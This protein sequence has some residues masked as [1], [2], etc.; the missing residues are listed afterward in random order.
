MGTVISILSSIRGGNFMASL[1]LLKVRFSDTYPTDFWEIS[2]PSGWC[3]MAVQSPGV[4]TVDLSLACQSSVG[5]GSLEGYLFP[6]LPLWLV[7]DSLDSLL[8]CQHR[9]HFLQFFLV[10]GIMMN[11]FIVTRYVETLSSECQALTKSM[12]KSFFQ[13]II[14]TLIFKKPFSVWSCFLSS[15]LNCYHMICKNVQKHESICKMSSAKEPRKYLRMTQ[16][17]S[18]STERFRNGMRPT[19]I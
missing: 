17:A 12:R 10:L 7:G 13:I 5:V 2:P 15:S 4:W 19:G 11:P 18:E 6:L 3:H 8:S 1:D 16:M 9:G 14:A